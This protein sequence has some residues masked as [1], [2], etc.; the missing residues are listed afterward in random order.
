MSETAF[1]LAASRLQYAAEEY[2]RALA[3]L[4]SNHTTVADRRAALVVRDEVERAF[5]DGTHDLA[6]IA[7][8]AAMVEYASRAEE[9]ADSESCDGKRWMC[10]RCLVRQFVDGPPKSPPKSPTLQDGTRWVRVSD[11][12][13][14]YMREPSA[15]VKVQIVERA[16]AEIELIA[17]RV[18]LPEWHECDGFICAECGPVRADEDGCCTIC[19]EDCAPGKIC[20]ALK[21]SDA[22]YQE[23]VSA[24]AKVAEVSA[25]NADLRAALEELT[26]LVRGECPSLLN[27]DSGGDARLALKIEAAL[28]TA[29]RP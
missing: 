21:L 3:L 27:E 20:V 6:R 9:C 24:R 16:G 29:S 10:L 13:I 1:G 17:T 8:F 4:A 5:R 23:E 25:S 28:E 15:A 7:E 22:E 12:M 18:P 11:Q 26:A 14:D 2:R 19:G